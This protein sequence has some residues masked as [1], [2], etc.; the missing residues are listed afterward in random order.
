MILAHAMLLRYKESQLTVS[1]TYLSRSY[2][3]K[4]MELPLAAITNC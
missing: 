4:V 2:Q 3:S 1:L